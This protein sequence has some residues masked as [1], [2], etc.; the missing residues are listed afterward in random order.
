M[1]EITLRQF[2]HFFPRRCCRCHITRETCSCSRLLLPSSQ[3]PKKIF[4]LLFL[5]L[6][7]FEIF[8]PYNNNGLLYYVF[9]TCVCELEF[10]HDFLSHWEG[11][12]RV[13]S[14]VSK[15]TCCVLRVVL[16]SVMVPTE[17]CGGGVLIV[18]PYTFFSIY[19]SA[20]FK[21][22]SSYC[23]ILLLRAFISS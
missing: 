2:R 16:L 11:E 23:I 15:P 10:L 19:Y 5:L 13:S 9:V 21:S 6:L 1:T 12:W 7:R 18:I 3:F 20:N 8:S 17:C 4:L 14:G 22:I